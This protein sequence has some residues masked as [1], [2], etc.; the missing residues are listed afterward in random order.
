MSVR[1]RAMKAIFL[2]LAAGSEQAGVRFQILI[3]RA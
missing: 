2:A 1:L 3:F